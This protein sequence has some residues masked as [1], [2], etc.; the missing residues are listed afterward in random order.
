[1]NYIVYI[2]I[3]CCN[4]WVIFGTKF[5]ILVRWRELF[6]TTLRIEFL[7]ITY[8]ICY[9]NV[10]S[11]RILLAWNVMLNV[12]LQTFTC[13]IKPMCFIL[14]LKA[15][16][17]LFSGLDYFSAKMSVGGG[18][19]NKKKSPR[20]HVFFPFHVAATSIG[21]REKKNAAVRFTTSRNRGKS[22]NFRPRF[23]HYPE[24]SWLPHKKWPIFDFRSFFS[25]CVADFHHRDVLSAVKL[26]I[27]ERKSTFIFFP[28]CHFLRPAER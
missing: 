11:L 14:T 22:A 17:I 9:W 7:Y 20:S 8:N 27:K 2:H 28:F 23:P 1:V 12:F 16:R 19:K 4:G 5:L 18:K 6:T 15:T 26:K 24:I 3:C 21:R 13:M 10:F 25:V